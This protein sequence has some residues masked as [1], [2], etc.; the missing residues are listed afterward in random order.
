MNESSSCLFCAIAQKKINAQI[1]AENSSVIAFHD[2]N[3][4]ADIHILIIPKIHV[5]GVNNINHNQADIMGDIF[6]M[7]QELADKY[8]LKE[9]GYRLVVNTEAGAG[10]SVFHLHVHF[11]AGC[12]FS[13][14]PGVSLSQK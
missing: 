14:P 7:A 1:V 12:E 9:H 5:R 3:P 2:I 6:M 11:L 8:A 13:W 10:Q 4:V